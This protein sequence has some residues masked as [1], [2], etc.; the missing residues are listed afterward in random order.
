MAMEKAPEVDIK[1]IKAEDGGVHH[2]GGGSR[3]V[4]IGWPGACACAY[5]VHEVND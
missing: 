2:F 1:P 4:R 3:D 5:T